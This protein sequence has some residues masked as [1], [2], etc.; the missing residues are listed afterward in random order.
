M[1]RRPIPIIREGCMRKTCYMCEKEAT[2]D[3]HVPPR[4]LFPEQKDLPKGL[5]FRKNLITVPSCD[6]HNSQKSKDDEYLLFLLLSA[7]QGNGDKQRHFD[8]KLLRAL[9]RRLHVLETFL[10]DMQPISMK[11]ENGEIDAGAAFRV[12]VPRFENVVKHM[13]MGIYFKHYELKWSG[14][15]RMFAN[16]MFDMTSPHANEIN[17]TISEVASEISRAFVDEATYGENGN[18]FSYKLY[19]GGEDRH[20][21]FMT[22]YEGFEITVLLQSNV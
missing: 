3:E 10:K 22:F 1:K 21:I 6:E 11:T 15:F 12:D 13:A 19:S 7:A 17:K 18:I 4:C 8:T 16:G 14:G 9:K 2:S 20:A 5:D